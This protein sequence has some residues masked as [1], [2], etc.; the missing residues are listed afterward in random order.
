MLKLQFVD[1]IQTSFW[2]V[3]ESFTIG[4]SGKN[5]MVIDLP[6]IQPFH[7]KIS[8]NETGGLMVS[9]ATSEGKVLV[10]YNII[11][12]ATPI[13]I[14]D[15]ITLQ[16]IEL[17]LIDPSKRQTPKPVPLSNLL[18]N[19]NKAQEQKT[20]L[21]PDKEVIKNTVIWKV[22]PLNTDLENQVVEIK[23]TIKIGRDPSNHIVI[24]GNHI[25]RRH[26]DFFLE[27]SQL[28]VRD[29]NSSNGTFVNGEQI[30]ERAIFLG[31]EVSFDS[32]KFMVTAGNSHNKIIDETGDKT[33]FRPAL[34]TKDINKQLINDTSHTSAIDNQS[35]DGLIADELIQTDIEHHRAMSRQ[36]VMFLLGVIVLIVLVFLFK[37]FL[38]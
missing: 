38:S 20:E 1:K 7:A 12:K 34:T 32:V 22:K 29:L 15:I 30:T 25:S 3:D 16:T 18:S 11:N 21:E 5:Q 10:N 6:E 19:T 24:E 31:D 4:S 28:M 9:P 36:S 13:V 8:T 26:A 27:E 23:D 2:I 14:G 17:K 35:L 37:F 33:Q